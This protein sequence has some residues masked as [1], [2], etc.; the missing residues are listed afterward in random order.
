MKNIDI[1]LRILKEAD[2]H[3]SILEKFNRYQITKRVK[4]KVDDKFL[5][6]DD[7]FIDH[8]DEEKK[9]EVIKSL[10][11]C[12]SMGGFVIG[13]FKNNQLIGFTN[14]ENKILGEKYKY[15]ELP[16]IHVSSEYRNH[17]IGKMLF[18]LCCEKARELGAQKLYI[19]AHPSE[20][21]QGFYE[22]V[23]CVYAEE[24]IKEISDREPLDIQ[25]EYLL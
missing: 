6:K 24:I 3:S 13:A 1:D 2:L 25:L 20:E 18:N 19:G 4:Y 15:V 17:G 9:K 12:I 14:V 22:S 23:G 7:H 16:Y 10:K 11:D 8:W 5:F 21:S